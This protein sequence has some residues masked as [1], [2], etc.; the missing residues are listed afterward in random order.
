[1][2][3]SML[4]VNVSPKL[5]VTQTSTYKLYYKTFSSENWREYAKFVLQSSGHLQYTMLRAYAKLSI[6]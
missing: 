6:S 3:K 2:T 1:M 4:T 5:I